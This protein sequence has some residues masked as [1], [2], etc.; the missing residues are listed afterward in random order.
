MQNMEGYLQRIRAEFPDFTF[1]NAR[2]V[3]DGADHLVFVIDEAWIFRFP[4]TDEYRESF[5]REVQLLNELYGKTAIRVPHYEFLSAEKD[6][7][8]YRMVPGEELKI[9]KFFALEEGAQLLIPKQMGGFLS[10]LHRLPEK[11]GVLNQGP[12]S[13]SSYEERYNNERRAV[14]ATHVSDEFLTKLDLFYVG[15]SKQHSSVRVVAHCDL[16]DDHILANIEGLTG[17]ID[18]GDAAVSDPALDFAFLWR[19]GDWV[20]QR[21]YEQYQHQGDET[22][23]L[24]SRW[25]F[26]R[27]LIDRIFYSIQDGE[28]ERIP[29]RVVLV[30]EELSKLSKYNRDK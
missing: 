10:V 8:G 29:E 17:I 14:F 5:K 13:Q 11:Y 30:E 18:F 24:R 16:T 21:A 19:Y 1:A 23:L 4:K 12:W 28:P 2:M 22:L 3:T 25:H 27:F 9:E 15:Y 6:F 20:P 26:V 7:G